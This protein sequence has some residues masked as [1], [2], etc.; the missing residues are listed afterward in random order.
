MSSI[1]WHRAMRPAAF[2]LPTLSTRRARAI[3]LVSV[4]TD[5]QGSELRLT[6]GAASTSSDRCCGR[7]RFSKVWRYAKNYS[8]GESHEA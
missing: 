8:L 5:T 4:R 7:F 6:A 1:L 2:T 3:A